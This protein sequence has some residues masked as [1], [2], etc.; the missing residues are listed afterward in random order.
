MH[1]NATRAWLEARQIAMRSPIG[2]HAE[3]T[4]FLIDAL[5]KAI[6]RLY[7]VKD[8]LLE[9]MADM[10]RE[11]DS[12]TSENVDLERENDDLREELEAVRRL[13]ETLLAQDNVAETPEKF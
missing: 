9:D 11:L 6:E 8:D 5:T 12:L 13:N 10:R 2:T 1:S 7:D 3:K 4:Q